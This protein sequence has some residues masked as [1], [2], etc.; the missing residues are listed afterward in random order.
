LTGRRTLRTFTGLGITDFVYEGWKA[1]EAVPRMLR[2]GD[3][4]TVLGRQLDLA[5]VQLILRRV[6][7]CNNGDLVRKHC[8]GISLAEKRAKERL[9]TLEPTT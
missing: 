8:A 5:L 3:S 7:V 9:I 6:T 1:K 4:R 2:C